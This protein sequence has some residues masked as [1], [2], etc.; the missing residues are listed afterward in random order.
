MGLNRTTPARD[1]GYQNIQYLRKNVTF[2][3][4]GKA[5]SVGVVPTG[6][7]ILKPISGAQVEE[8]FNAATTNTIDI[9]TAA[10]ADLYGTALAAG[11]V[12]F[13]PIDEAVALTVG[14]DTEI[15]ATVGLTG[16][17]ATTGKAT[18][19]IAFIPAN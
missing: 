1:A 15:L 5:V 18:I 14:A 2:A 7:L 16:T 11:A 12:A 6:A 8:A 10:N 19:V 13:V 17:A 4:N 3:D 9:G